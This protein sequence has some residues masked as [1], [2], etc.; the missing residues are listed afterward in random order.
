MNNYKLSENAKEDLKRIYFYGFE[1]F[2]EQEADLYYDAFFDAF[3]RI[4]SNPRIYP[5]IDNIRKGYHRCP[6]GSDS[7]YYRIKNDVV[8]I[9]SII[10]GQDTDVWL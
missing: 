9:M 7:I 3:E 8:E 4:A 6:C 5:M 1:N 2:G 10:G